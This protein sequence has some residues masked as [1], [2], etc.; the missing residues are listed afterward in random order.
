MLGRGAPELVSNM[1]IRIRIHSRFDNDKLYVSLYDYYDAIKTRRFCTYDVRQD[2]IYFKFY[3]DNANDRYHLYPLSANNEYSVGDT[4][5]FQM[6]NDEQRSKFIS[7][8][9]YPVFYDKDTDMYSIRLE[10]V[11]RT[12]LFNLDTIEKEKSM[13]GNKSF[14]IDGEKL[15]NEFKVRN[16]TLSEAATKCG[17]NVGYFSYACKHGRLTK[18]AINLLHA[19]YN[20]KYDDYKLEDEIP[21]KR[22]FVTAIITDENSNKLYQIIYSAMYHAMKQA[23]SE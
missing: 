3:E 22:E 5:C 2:K 9:S 6:K 18:P 10:D 19:N 17:F 11:E 23:L 8:Y 20:I 16:V 1:R 4:L 12:R 14:K 15:R 21:V 13:V 7:D